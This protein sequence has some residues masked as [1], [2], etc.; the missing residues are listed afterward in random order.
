MTLLEPTLNRIGA[1]P[2][3]WEGVFATALFLLCLALY[4]KTF[5]HIWA[6]WNLQAMESSIQYKKW[7]GGWRSFWQL[8][9]LAF[10]AF[11]P[12]IAVAVALWLTR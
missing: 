1:T 5:G 7:L 4:R 11:V 6:W 9:W 8:A 2:D 3:E 12:V 10:V